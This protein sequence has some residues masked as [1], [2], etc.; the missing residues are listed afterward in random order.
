MV[1]ENTFAWNPRLI[2]SRPNEG[3]RIS[4][5][6]GFPSLDLTLIATAISELGRNILTY[7]RSEKLSKRA[8]IRTASTASSWLPA[9][10]A[11]HPDV[12]AGH[13][14][15]FLHEA[16]GWSMG[17][18]EQKRLMHEFQISSEPGWARR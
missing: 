5:P 8:R 1:D 2:S 17:C 9:T 18:R 13:G 11:R 15:W 4:E 10:T 14:G 6:T 3:T 12:E 7:A 16:A